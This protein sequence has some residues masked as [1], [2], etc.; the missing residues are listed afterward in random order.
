MN[1]RDHFIERMKEQ[2]AQ[3]KEQVADIERAFRAASERI[4]AEFEEEWMKISSEFQSAEEELWA[5]KAADKTVR[6][7]MQSELL[8]AWKHLGRRVDKFRS[9]NSDE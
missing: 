6:E 9:R 1:D 5:L 7:E 2:L 4:K 3:M 8:A